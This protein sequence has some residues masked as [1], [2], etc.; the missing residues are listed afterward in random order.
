MD[1]GRTE[2]LPVLRGKADNPSMA[3][4]KHSICGMRK[5]KMQ[6]ESKH[7]IERVERHKQAYCHMEQE[8]KRCV[9][10]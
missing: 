2:T 10:S 9:R 4:F 8:G 6:D 1:S 7:R 3:C 5:S